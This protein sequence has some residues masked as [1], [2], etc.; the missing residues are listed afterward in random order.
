MVK[1]KANS[2][3]AAGSK[4]EEESI[5]SKEAPISE[6]AATNPTEGYPPLVIDLA[7]LLFYQEHG[8]GLKFE[9][10]AND[11]REE[12][13]R[14]ATAVFI[15]LDKMNKRVVTKEDIAV[16]ERRHMK[17]IDILK[18]I[19]ENFVVNIKLLKCGTCGKDRKVRL[20]MFPSEELAHKILNGDVQ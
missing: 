8:S 7:S 1:T 17:N 16:T 4:N 20:S 13:F 3:L 5:V 18:T 14:R 15:V 10:L 11:L 2:K 12:W 6:T 9:Y 19:I